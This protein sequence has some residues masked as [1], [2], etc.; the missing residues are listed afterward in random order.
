MYVETVRLHYGQFEDWEDHDSPW[1]Y[2]IV[3]D[4]TPE[5]KWSGRYKRGQACNDLLC[6]QDK[7]CASSFT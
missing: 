7:K 2:V 6:R 5:R 1:V 4:L 3:E